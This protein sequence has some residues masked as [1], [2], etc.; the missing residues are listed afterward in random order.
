MA[1]HG[2]VSSSRGLSLRFPRFIKPRDDKSIELASSPS[3]LVEIWKSQ[4]GKEKNTSG[5]DEGE[6]VDAEPEDSEFE[7]SNESG[8]D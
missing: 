3:F 5:K 2:I 7:S 8:M 4:Q 1:A 6:L